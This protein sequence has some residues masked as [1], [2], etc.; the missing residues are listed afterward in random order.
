[1]PIILLVFALILSHSGH[2]LHPLRFCTYTCIIRTPVDM[3]TLL[4]VFGLTRATYV[5][6]NAVENANASEVNLDIENRQCVNAIKRINSFFLFLALGLSLRLHLSHAWTSLTQAHMQTLSD[7]S[8]HLG[9]P[10]PCVCMC[11][12]ITCEHPLYV[13]PVSLG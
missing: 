2:T 9:K 3:D 13:A 11:I 4:R 8:C 10:L 1:M 7:W 5:Q 12:W 6:I